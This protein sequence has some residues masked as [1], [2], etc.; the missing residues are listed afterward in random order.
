M[1]DQKMQE[2]FPLAFKEMKAKHPNYG[3]NTKLNS[4]DQWWRELIRLSLRH[5]GIRRRTSDM[6]RGT[7]VKSLLQRFSSSG[8]YKLNEGVPEIFASLRELKAQRRKEGGVVVG[9]SD[10]GAFDIEHD[11]HW[12]LATNSD[13][14][15]LLACQSLD[16]HQHIDVTIK[17]GANLGKQHLKE[18]SGSATPPPPPLFPKRRSMN[19]E[20]FLSYFLGYE[21]PDPNFFHLAVQKAFSSL[22]PPNDSSSTTPPPLSDLCAQTL[23]VGDHYHE[24]YVGAREAGLQ[25]AWLKRSQ[26]WPAG[27]TQ[28]QKG[29]VVALE[30]IE[31]VPAIIRK[32]WA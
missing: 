1:T 7:M 16:L 27:L 3:Y 20:P 19:S 28:A 2:A 21:K 10:E 30:S 5:G 12:N 32:S 18:M 26:D 17:K 9:A 23:F 31:E 25:A 13:A 6:I 4:A 24:D 29:D 8:A 22:Y 14:R 11:L 15:I